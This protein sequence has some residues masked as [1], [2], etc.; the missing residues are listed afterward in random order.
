M[1]Q[2]LEEVISGIVKERFADAVIDSITV[3]ADVDSDGD[4]ILRVT[5]VFDSEIAK[6][7]P[8]K[9]AGLARHVRPKIMERNDAA[10]PIFRFMSKR[11]N[12]RLRHAAA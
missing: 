11:D 5:V 6:I 10:F 8:S 2:T 7:E 9:L 12:E 1:A 4:P 3:M